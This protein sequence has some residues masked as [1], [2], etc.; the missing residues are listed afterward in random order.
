MRGCIKKTPPLHFCT[1]CETKKTKDDFYKCSK[2]T[3]GHKTWCIKCEREYHRNYIRTRGNTGCWWV[4]DYIKMSEIERRI[5]R[6][7]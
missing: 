5:M 7:G 3:N 6:N 2:N 4:D 1:K